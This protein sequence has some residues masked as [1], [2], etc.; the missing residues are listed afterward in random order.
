MN[1]RVYTTIYAYFACFNVTLIANTT[2]FFHVLSN[3]NFTIN[4]LAENEGRDLWHY[5]YIFGS[6]RTFRGD[7]LQRIHIHIFE[8]ELFSS[9]YF[10]PEEYLTL[11]ADGKQTDAVWEFNVNS[12]E[13]NYI[14]FIFDIPYIFPTADYSNYIGVVIILISLPFVMM[15]VIIIRGKSSE[16]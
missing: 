8:E 12:V 2:I 9:K 7:T 3:Y 16:L 15:V 6:A 5:R 13:G 11:T 10:M 1:Y 14:T 4:H